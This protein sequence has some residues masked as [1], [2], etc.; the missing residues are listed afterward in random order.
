MALVECPDCGRQI[1]D[2]AP[3]C[4][5]CGRPAEE[6]AL[7]NPQGARVCTECGSGQ[8]RRYSIVFEE[9]KTTATGGVVGFGT[10]LGG[11]GGIGIGGGRSGSLTELGKRVAPPRRSDFKYKPPADNRLGIFAGGFLGS[12]FLA[13][14][15]GQRL[16][17][18]GWIA[19]AVFFVSISGIIWIIK[20]MP[21]V[22]SEDDSEERYREAR[23]AWENKYLC[24]QC[25]A[26]VIEPAV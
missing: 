3:A 4:P 11:S 14:A 10:G 5:Q 13:A 21:P 9:S 12:L 26:E 18:W 8:V 23:E 7:P 19:I 1:S 25:G 6:R 15:V 20:Q 24:I 16:G 2:A 17:M 22:I